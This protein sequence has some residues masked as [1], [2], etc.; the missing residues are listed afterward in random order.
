MFTFKELKQIHLEITNNC[1]A[2]CPMCSRNIHG[3]LEN[4]LL[5]LHSWSLDM[6]KSIMTQEVLDQIS[7]YYFC[8]NFGDPILNNDLPD[9]CEYS[10]KVA[11]NT[12]IRIHTNGGGRSTQW[13]ANL[14]KVLPKNHSVIFAIDGLTGTH[15]LYRIGTTFEKVITNAS[16][17]INAGGHAE[18]AFIR[19]KHN[20]HQVEECRQLAA[21]LKFATFT[22]KDSSR[23]LLDKRFAVY[24][25]QDQITHYMEPSEYS[26]I[27]FIDRKAISNYKSIVA[28]TEIRCQALDFKEVYIDA[29]GR[30]F[31]CCYLAM[32]PYIPL[33]T[34]FEITAIRHEILKEYNALVADLGGIDA[35]DGRLHSVKNIVDSTPYQ[36][37][38]H[39]YW[40]EEKLITC[41]RSCGVTADF[42]NPR[43]QFTSVESL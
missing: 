37:V 16:A 36:T 6:F 4:P 7:S 14:A 9:M 28:N 24:N 23:F 13:W 27:K 22:M 5:Q 2:S 15:E 41:T 43:D 29:F 25:K 42:S 8:G 26:E 12:G 38:W 30:V 21:K 19:F 10:V 17:F 40:N 3:G 31:P 1:Q 34:E 11:P 35:L 20:E 39:K 33:D 18:W 32:I